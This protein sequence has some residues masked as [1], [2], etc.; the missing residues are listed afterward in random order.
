MNEASINGWP[1]DAVIISDEQYQT[2]L[3]GQVSGKVITADSQV[4]PILSDPVIDWQACS[5]QHRQNLLTVANATMADWHTELQLD[6]ISD[7]EKSCLIKWMVYINAVKA[8]D[9]SAINDEEGYK[10]VIWPIVP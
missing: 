2:L 6:V 4:N 8:L 10:T 3:K 1:G 9:L 5:E 7:E